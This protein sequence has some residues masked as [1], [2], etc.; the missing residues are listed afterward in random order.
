MDKLGPMARSVEDC[1]VMLGLLHGRDP[2]DAASV[3]K[4]FHWPG[5]RSLKSLTVGYFENAM[6]SSMK[7]VVETLKGIGCTLKPINLP[8]RIPMQAM[9]LILGAE[10]ACAFEELTREGISEGIGLWPITF[11]EARFTTAV[12]YLRANRLRTLLMEDMASVMKTVDLYIGGNDLQITNLTG[13]PSICL[14][15]GHA[16]TND[17]WRPLTMTMTGR[18]FGETEL[19]TVARAYQ[20]ATG[21]HLK[22]PML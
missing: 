5:Y 15:V 9:S 22:R 18:L 1:A 21:H 16:K 2:A 13:H 11:R 14:P 4:P 12:D 6:T 17:R 10:A 7:E 8:T 19:L 20:E 3:T